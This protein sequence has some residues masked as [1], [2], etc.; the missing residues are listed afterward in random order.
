VPV[1]LRHTSRAERT[2]VT[3]L[4]PGNELRRIVGANGMPIEPPATG[5][6]LTTRLA[7]QLR[8]RPADMVTVEVLEGRRPTRNMLVTGTVDELIGAGA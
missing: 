6:L 2:A 8:V 3:G 5:L 7:A 4:E 1:R